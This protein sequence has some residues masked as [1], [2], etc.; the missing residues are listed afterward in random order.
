MTNGTINSQI[1][2]PKQ[3]VRLRILNAEIDRGYNLGFSDNSSF[4]VIGN[5]GGLLNAP[6]TTTRVKLMVGERV[7]I[8]VNLSNDAE[9]RR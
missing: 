3:Y 7:E 6:I 4:Q 5:D 9:E 8:M 2:L 1:S